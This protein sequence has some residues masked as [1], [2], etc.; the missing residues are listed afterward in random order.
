MNGPDWQAR[1]GLLGGRFDPPHRGHAEAARGVL[2]N[3]GLREVWWLP[4]GRTA[5]KPTAASARH[6][7]ALCRILLAEP[8]WQAL[9]LRLETCELQRASM[10]H[11]PTYSFE[12]LEA[13]TQRGGSARWAFI[14]GGDAFLGIEGWHRFPE[15]LRLCSWVVLERSGG[16]V[17]AVQRLLQKFRAQG[18]LG[19]PLGQAWPV[20]GSG[21][22]VGVFKTEARELSSTQVRET[23]ALQGRVPQGSMGSEAVDYLKAH[24]LYGMPSPHVAK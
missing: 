13:L 11:D 10:S 6:R 3:P 22:W 20:S 7:E 15:V 4:A 19:T 18:L 24:R 5:H 14:L 8:E 12:T 2:K 9:P 16:P 17:E 21:H 1:I 23:I